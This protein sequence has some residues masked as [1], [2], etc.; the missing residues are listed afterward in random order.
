MGRISIL[1]P[2]TG[3]VR[4][5]VSGLPSGFS[6]PNGDPSGPSGLALQGNTLFVTIGLG[7]AVVAGPLP[8]TQIPNPTPSSPLFSS[9]LAFRLTRHGSVLNA[10][11]TMTPADQA[12]LKSNSSTTLYNAN[13]D[14]L[15]VRLIADFPDYLPEPVPGAL[16]NVRQSNP[17]G[18]AAIDNLLYVPDASSNNLRVVNLDTG[19]SR[20]CRISLR[21]QIA[22]SRLDLQWSKPF[23]T[24]SAD[25]ETGSS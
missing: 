12:A 17:F 2:G 8:G 4:T 20:H 6:P 14:Q 13:S 3:Q 1:D 19:A 5:L 23:P 7:D 9:V 15:T 16:A 22:C 11:F 25:L 10:G 18:I 21:C 24:A